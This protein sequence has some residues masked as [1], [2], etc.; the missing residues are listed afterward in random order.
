[1]NALKNRWLIAACAVG[2]HISLGSVYAYSVW[3]LPLNQAHGWQKPDISLAFSLAILLLGFSAAFAGPRIE[4]MGPRNS[5]R[6]SGLFYALGQLGA[7]LGVQIGSLALFTLSYGI[8]GGIGLGIG[9]ITPVSSLVK[10]F[11]DKRGLATGMAIMGFG[12]GSMVFGPI[13]AWLCA[14]TGPAAALAILGVLFFFLIFASSLYLAPPP[15]GWTPE[16]A[17]PAPL[18]KTAK[19]MRPMGDIAQLNAREA[20]GTLRFY[21]IWLLMFINISCGIGLIAVA[22]PMAQEMAGMSAFKAASLVGVMGLFNGLGRIAWSS[23][24]DYMGRPATFAA[25]FVLQAIAFFF[26]NTSSA[27]LFQAMLLLIMTCYGGG[28]AT[29]PAFLSDMFGLKQLGTIHGYTLTAWGI[30]G[31]VGP[32]LVSYLYETTGNYTITIRI[33][34]ASMVAGFIISILLAKNISALRRLTD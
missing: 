3:V 17:K 29:L 6:L 18:A 25:F 27:F 30:A 31:I 10:W 32:A 8:I 15:F 4:A 5:G 2:I 28:F 26:M 7:A 19:P 34:A 14:L 1:M 9:Y 24:S 21:C 12:F 16:N 22:S 23:L 11:P 13:I 20:L 33:F